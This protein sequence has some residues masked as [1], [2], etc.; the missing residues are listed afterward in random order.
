MISGKVSPSR[1]AAIELNVSGPTQQPQRTEVVIDTGF[2]GYLTLPE[3]RIHDLK[4]PFV[5][6]RRAT[7]GDGNVVVLD[8]YLATV[9]WHGQ[10]REVLALPSEGGPLIGMSLLSS[11]RVTLDVVEGGA[12]RIDELPGAGHAS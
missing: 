8:V 7:L 3:K 10:E 12:V 4:L 6:N 5:G 2:N 9:S 11:S 1:E